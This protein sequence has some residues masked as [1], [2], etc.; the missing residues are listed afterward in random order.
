MRGFLEPD[1]PYINRKH[2]GWRRRRHASLDIATFFNGHKSCVTSAPPICGTDVETCI[3]GVTGQAGIKTQL[4]VPLITAFVAKDR[5]AD[6]WVF[7]QMMYHRLLD[8]VNAH[9]AVLDQLLRFGGSFGV[10]MCK[11]H[12]PNVALFQKALDLA[13]RVAHD[14]R[15]FVEIEH[16]VEGRQKRVGDDKRS[17]RALKNPTSAIE[18]P[19]ISTTSSSITSPSAMNVSI[20]PSV[21][22]IQSRYSAFRS[23]CSP[24]GKACTI[25]LAFNMLSATRSARFLCPHDGGASL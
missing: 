20:E 5:K 2:A 25:V 8:S 4:C 11:Q 10:V 13:E 18:W 22:P 24:S 1:A 16:R 23:K 15:I 3:A 19:I 17:G 6:A 14:I 21:G 12:G 9:A 7:L